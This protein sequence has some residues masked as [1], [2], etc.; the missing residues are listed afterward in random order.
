[1]SKKRHEIKKKN[2]KK[3]VKF[4]TKKKYKIEVSYVIIDM[5]EIIFFK[6][7]KGKRI[8]MKFILSVLF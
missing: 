1:M 7:K 5:V 6:K 3:S 4:L 2:P 8:G